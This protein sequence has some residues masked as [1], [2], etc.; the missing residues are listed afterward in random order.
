MMCTAGMSLAWMD[1]SL[2]VELASWHRP[3][4][5]AQW[6]F[7]ERQAATARR[8]V[9]ACLIKNSWSLQRCSLAPYRSNMLSG[10]GSTK[11]VV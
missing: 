6:K 4:S 7:G 10:H 3:M 5:F 1:V 8:A 9:A 11:N 2:E